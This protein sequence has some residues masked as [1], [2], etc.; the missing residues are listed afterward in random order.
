MLSADPRRLY[1][2]VGSLGVSGLPF[3][4]GVS[5]YGVE[6]Y[7]MAD[8]ILIKGFRDQ[9]RNHRLHVISMRSFKE[10]NKLII[11]FFISNVDY[12]H[13]PVTYSS[14][15]CGQEMILQLDNKIFLREYHK[16][17][18]GYDEE[19]GGET[20]RPTRRS[21]ESREETRNGELIRI[22]QEPSS[23]VASTNNQSFNFPSGNED[24]MV[25]SSESENDESKDFE[26]EAD[27]IPYRSPHQQI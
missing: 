4:V 2:L 1:H 14:G 11:N 19:D 3:I 17:V 21:V 25:L 6:K 18:V 10:R 12:R 9:L 7:K 27:T 23:L 22:K 20:N 8:G 16:F 26:M 24:I 5:L 13:S 15:E